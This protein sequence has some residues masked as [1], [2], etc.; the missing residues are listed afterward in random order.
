MGVVNVVPSSIS[1][2]TV[3]FNPIDEKEIKSLSREYLAIENMKFIVSAGRLVE[4]KDFETLIKA[5]HLLILDGL[6]IK[7]ILLGEGNHGPK[8]EQLIMELKLQ[9]QIKLAGFQSNP[10]KWI[11]RAQC[12][13]LSSRNEG[14]PTVILE[15]MA[16]DVPIISTDCPS[17]PREILGNNEFG[18]LTPVE[19]YQV[20]FEKIKLL[21][22]NQDILTKYKTASGIRAKDFELIS[23]IDQWQ[24]LFSDIISKKT[25]SAPCILLKN[26]S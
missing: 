8:L 9:N 14:L 21:L 18:M 23:I 1:I 20:L 2:A 22:T 11:V 16:L 3:I 7:L 10:Y 25:K 6:E 4:D 15:A 12:F 13:V 26:I 17:G 24:F 19:D 5:F